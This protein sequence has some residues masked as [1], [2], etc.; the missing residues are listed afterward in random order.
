MDRIFLFT[1]TSRLIG[2]SYV[3]VNDTPFP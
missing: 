3:M 1:M 2:A